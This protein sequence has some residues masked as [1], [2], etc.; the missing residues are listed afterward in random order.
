MRNE[1]GESIS[2]SMTSGEMDIFINLCRTASIYMTGLHLDLQRER[3]P[4]K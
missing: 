3:E 1:A 4:K 2:T